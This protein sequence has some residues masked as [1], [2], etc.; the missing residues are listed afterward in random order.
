MF[1]TLRSKLLF[2]TIVS[3]VLINLVFTI[4]IALFLENTL[5]SDIINEITNI[6]KFSINTINQ[7]ELIGE[8]KWKSL[9]SIKELTNSY[10]SMINDKGEINE[11]VS[12][13]ISEEEINNI[14]NTIHGSSFI[15][16]LGDKSVGIIVGTVLFGI[17]F[18]LNYWYVR[19]Q[20]YKD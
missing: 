17:Y 8:S 14:V 20:V 9:N 19:R 6:K 12:V 18:I 5:R 2:G 10:V 11:F 7:N 15:Q 1:K 3:V 13:L 4:F 16:T